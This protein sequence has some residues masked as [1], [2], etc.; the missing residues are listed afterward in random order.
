[1]PYSFIEHLARSVLFAQ[2]SDDALIAMFTAYFDAS[3]HPDRRSV[4]TVAGFVSTVKKWTRFDTEWNA[5][6]KSEGVKVFHMTD[7]VSSQGEFAVGW[8]GETDK[9]RVFIERLVA[10]LKKNVN[11]AFRATVVLTDYQEAN[12][13][14]QLEE[15]VGPPYSFCSMVCVYTL[16][17]WA[18]RKNGLRKTLYY[19]EDGDKDKGEFERAH[20]AAYKINPKFLD[21]TEAVAFQAADLTGWKIRSSIEGAIKSDHTPEKGA[22]LL[23]SVEMLQAIPKDAGVVNREVLAKYCIAWKVPKRVMVSP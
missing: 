7:F 11:K 3:G 14:Y 4:L 8:K 23:Q 18:A 12:E 2:Y 5:I 10:C 22:R 20:K 17:R 1:M 6:L 21:K 19:F 9:R 16:R 15:F 13:S